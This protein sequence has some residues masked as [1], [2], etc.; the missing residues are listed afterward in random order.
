M[1]GSHGHIHV[2]ED[3]HGDKRLR[4]ACLFRS[5]Y[6][7]AGVL[8]AS[9]VAECFHI[10]CYIGRLQV[11]CMLHLCADHGFLF[12]ETEERGISAV[13]FDT[14]RAGTCPAEHPGDQ[15]TQRHRAV[16]ADA[17][18]SDAYRRRRQSIRSALSWCSNSICG[19]YE[20]RTA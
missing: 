6:E 12:R 20:E 19:S 7:H 10:V 11:S 5:G 14:G 3:D 1:Y 8:R 15:G 17:F 18:R 9:C 16:S 2:G 13:L 4:T